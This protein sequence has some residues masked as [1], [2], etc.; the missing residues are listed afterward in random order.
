M[1]GSSDARG[2]DEKLFGKNVVISQLNLVINVVISPRKD[3]VRPGNGKGDGHKYIS[4]SRGK[5]T[6][7]VRGAMLEPT[8]LLWEWR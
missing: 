2:R 8:R 7:A 4:N 1:M 6:G 3:K 5:A